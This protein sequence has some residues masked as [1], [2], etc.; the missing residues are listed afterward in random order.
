MEGF[1]LLILYVIAKHVVCS[2]PL[3]CLLELTTSTLEGRITYAFV[4]YV[5]FVFAN[6]SS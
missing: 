2:A 4:V 5:A 6:C 1:E 3:L